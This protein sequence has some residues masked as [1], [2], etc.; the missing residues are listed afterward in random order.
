[1]THTS[2]MQ[3]AREVERFE[4]SLMGTREDRAD[5]IPDPD[6]DYVRH[7]DYAAL[8]SETAAKDA[9]IERLKA[10]LREAEDQRDAL[11][12]DVH[13]MGQRIEAAEAEAA[14]LR[15]ALEEIRDMPVMNAVEIYEIARAALKSAERQP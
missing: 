9:E 6:G 4:P 14:A 2:A 12:G 5:C 3:K 11:N 7:S 13:E 8:I 1:M 10:A 15:K